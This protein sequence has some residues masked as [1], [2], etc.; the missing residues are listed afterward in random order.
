[1]WRS[2]L[3]IQPDHLWSSNLTTLVL[4][5]RSWMPC[6]P[7][8]SSSQ[9]DPLPIRRPSPRPCADFPATQIPH[10][11]S[12][13][14]PLPSPHRT[15]YNHYGLNRGTHDGKAGLWYREWAPGAKSLALVGE[16]NDWSPLPEHW[17]AKNAFGV[18]E[19]FLPDGADG[20]PVVPHK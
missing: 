2:C 10:S 12:P 3:E 13:P 19:L 17:G 5:P 1:M 11:L 6:P 20:K 7:R 14:L 15:G 18:F 4:V 9:F 16:F 8:N